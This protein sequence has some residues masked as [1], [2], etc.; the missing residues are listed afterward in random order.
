MPGLRSPGWSVEAAWPSFAELLDSKSSKQ[1][2]SHH[3][4]RS[5]ARDGSMRVGL[6][7]QTGSISSSRS[8]A[9]GSGEV[10]A[11]HCKDLQLEMGE[12]VLLP[13]SCAC[14]PSKVLINPP[15]GCA[16]LQVHQG[17][18]ALSKGA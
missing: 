6:T 17:S 1:F 15:P 10:P 2:C 16:R 18:E 14:S 4:G 11:H 13:I 3:L 12:R 9:C 8:N 5:G 7:H